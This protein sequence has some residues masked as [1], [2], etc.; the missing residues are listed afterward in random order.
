MAVAPSLIS[1]R[2]QETKYFFSD[3]VFGEEHTIE[4]PSN[5]YNLPQTAQSEDSSLGTV[6]TVVASAVVVAAVEANDNQELTDIDAT[7][8]YHPVNL[9]Y[10]PITDQFKICEGE[11][12]L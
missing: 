12:V 3:N 1:R 7:D 8:G 6:N 2:G 10:N 4:F 5:G 9:T 11:Y